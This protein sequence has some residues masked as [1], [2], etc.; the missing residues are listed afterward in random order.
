MSSLSRSRPRSSS[1]CRVDRLDVSAHTIP[2]DAPESDGTLEWD[3]TTIVVVQAQAGGKVGLGYT[4][5][6]DAA[7]RLIADHLAPAVRG[8]DLGK[9]TSSVWHEMGDLLRNLGR[10]GMGFMALSAVDI[11]LWDLKARLQ[12]RPLVDVLGREKEDVAVYGSGGFTSYA[13]ERIAEQ[14]AGWV[15]AGGVALAYA[16]TPTSKLG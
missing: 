15:A 7:A 9:D 5:T 10:P 1:S 16:L 2:T 8:F 14:L 4:Y 12:E 6:H 13:L 3:S 11:A